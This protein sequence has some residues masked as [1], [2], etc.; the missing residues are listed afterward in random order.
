[1]AITDPELIRFSNEVI[2]RAADLMANLY[3]DCAYLKQLKDADG[4]TQL[5]IDI[6]ETFIR[7][8]SDKMRDWLTNSSTRENVWFNVGNPTPYN[9]QFPNDPAEDVVDGSP[10]DGR[11]PISGA[12]VHEV[13]TQLIQFQNWWNDAAFGGPGTGGQLEAMT[14]TIIV[15]GGDGNNPLIVAQVDNFVDNRCNE[16][17]VEYEANSSAKL[18][19]LLKVAPNPRNPE[20][21]QV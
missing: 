19:S 16:I 15:V 1:M 13:M 14:N 21:P 9:T 11:P 6:R 12:D 7:G 3:Y 5:T 10:A 18:N 2:R 4:N 20:A 17:K 8:T